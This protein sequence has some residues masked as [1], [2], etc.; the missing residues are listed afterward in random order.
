MKATPNDEI[1]LRVKNLNV[2]INLHFTNSVRRNVIP[3]NLKSQW[4]AVK[5]PK[6]ANYEEMPNKQFR[7]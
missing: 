1:K 2:E 4:Q 7:F 6:D 3:G 5:A